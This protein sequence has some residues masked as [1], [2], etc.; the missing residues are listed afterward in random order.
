MAARKPWRIH[1]LDAAVVALLLLF[2]FYGIGFD[3]LGEPGLPAADVTEYVLGVVATVPLLLWRR[4]PITAFGFVAGAVAVSLALGYAFGPVMFQLMLATTML[5]WKVQGSPLYRVGVG[6]GVVLIGAFA[7]RYALLANDPAA[8]LLRWVTSAFLWLVLPAVVGVGLRLQ[9][10]TRSRVRAERARRAA[11]EEQL[12]IAQELHDIVGHGL[13]VIAMQAGAG[14]HVLERDP[15]RAGKALTAIEDTARAAL[16]GLRAEVANL[17]AGDPPVAADSARL[18]PSDGISDLPRLVERIRSGGVPVVLDLDPGLD[19]RS[20]PVDTDH[21][22]YRIVQ[23]ALTNVLRHGG[24]RATARVEV[25]STGTDLVVDVTNTDPRPPGTAPDEPEVVA[26][27]GIRGMH[28]RAQRLGG[29][30]ETGRRPEGG[31][32]V[33]A[34]LPSPASVSAGRP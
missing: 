10:E 19:A 4:F 2:V 34:T 30:L 33:S 16:D 29:R 18:T 17:Q 6:Y 7:M 5:T 3:A 22:A 25:R 9:Q 26:G 8:F 31:F 28:R 11:A 12:R 27:L 20:V 21:A 23:E 15:R 1:W 13:A 24:P 32:R 14:R